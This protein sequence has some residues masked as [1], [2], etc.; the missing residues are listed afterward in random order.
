MQLNSLS[1]KHLR[2][3]S[4]VDLTLN[5]QFNIFYG[6]NGGG[7]TSLLEAVHVLTTGRS[8][9]AHH[10][11]QIITFGEASCLIAGTVKVKTPEDV[12]HSIHLGVERFQTGNIK[13]RIADEDCPSIAALAKTVAVQ[14]INSDSY[15]ILEAA[16]QVRRQFLDWILFHVEPSFYPIWQRCRRV[17]QQRNAA[18]RTGKPAVLPKQVQIWDKEFIE[19]GEALAAQRK[20]I[21]TVFI[22]IFLEIIGCLLNLTDVTIRYQPGWNQ[23]YSLLEALK[24]SFERDLSGGYTTVGPHRADVEFLMNGDVSVK[25]V[26]SRGQLKLFICAL[27]LA[28]ATLLYQQ[29]GRRCIFL[30]DDLNSELDQPAS[31]L[32]AA[33]LAEL[34]SQVFITSVEERSVAKFLENNHYQLWHLK[35]GQCWAGV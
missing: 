10:A 1:I 5:P 12:Q 9:R 19:M 3:L 16:P 34:D 15:D 4:S 11:R 29:Q 8:F 28:R 31:K 25:N 6:E 24:N 13:I 30:I 7:K 32:L 21:L 22:P 20:A 2:N 26:L 23:E 27:L 14:L 33:A 18:L 35:K 17:L